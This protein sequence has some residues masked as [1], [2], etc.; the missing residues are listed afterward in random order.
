ME[1][2]KLV[3]YNVVLLQSVQVVGNQ[4]GLIRTYF[5]HVVYETIGGYDTKE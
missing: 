3:V 2:G 4:K 1:L 5:W